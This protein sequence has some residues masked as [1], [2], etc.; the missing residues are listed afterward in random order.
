M[1]SGNK[2]DR[3]MPAKAVIFARKSTADKQIQSIPAQIHACR[4]LCEA[5]GYE[6]V[7][8]YIS[9]G[10]SGAAD[11]SKRETLLQMLESLNDG[12]VVIAR[13][14]SRLGRSVG[15]VLWLEDE[16]K[17][18]GCSLKLVDGD[19]S[20]SPESK[21]LHHIK[22]AVAEYEVHQLR[23]RVLS[24]LRARKAAGV[25]LGAPNRQSYGWSRNEG[26]K[27]AINR[28]EQQTIERMKTLREHGLSYEAVGKVLAAEQIFNRNGKPFAAASVRNAV[29]IKAG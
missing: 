11:I 13:S 24:G 7:R 14:S 25:A 28:S 16:I 9:E 8:T 5:E 3:E 2:E 6:V 4:E 12:E 22:L 10:V 20:D 17:R 19:N 27:L 15:V 1:S 18:K 29:L 23:W 21:L 26:G